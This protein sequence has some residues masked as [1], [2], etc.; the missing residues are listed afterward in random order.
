MTGVPNFPSYTSG[1]STFS[2][3]AATVLSYIFPTNASK[4]DA[5]AK[6]ASISRLMGGIHYRMDCEY[7]LKYGAL[8]GAK[9]VER[10]QND[11]VK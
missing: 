7:G 9:A 11:G 10:G 5:M 4:F 8:V 2:A 3:A 1:H 6:E